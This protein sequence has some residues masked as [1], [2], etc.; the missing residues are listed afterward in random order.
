[1]MRTNSIFRTPSAYEFPLLIKHLWITPLANAPDEQIVYRSERRQTYAQTR[2]RVGRLASMLSA[3]G[4]TQGKTVALL[5][6]DSH[7]YFECFFAIPMMGCVLQTVNIRLSPDQLLYTLNHAG[8]EIVLV[9]SDFLPLLGAVRDRL[10]T[11]KKFI[12]I[13]DGTSQADAPLAFVGEYEALLADADPDYAFADLD[14]NSRATT[15]YTTGTTGLPKGVY[16]SHRQIVL[17][18]LALMSWLGTAPA[19]GRLHREDVYMPMTPMF[20]VHAWGLPFV[21]TLMG[22]KQIY[23][24]RYSPDV[25]LRLIRDERVTFSHCVPTVL[26]MLLSHPASKDLDMSRLKVMVG[27]SALPAGLA[28]T[29]LERNIDVFCGYGMSE[30][31]PVQVLNHLSSDELGACRDEQAKLRTRTGRAIVL[32]EVS[33]VD[34]D[35]RPVPRD[36]RNRGEI[37]FRSPWLTQ[38]YVDDP[39]RSE[40]LWRGGVLHS[41]DIG[42]FTA[43]GCLQISDRLKDVIKS[44]G[45]WISSLDLENIISEIPGVAEVAVIAVAD[46][47]WGERPLALIVPQ[48][49]AN[50]GL[51]AVRAHL[52]ACA[53]RG[54][55]SKYG[56]PDR[57]IIV[58]KL[59]RTSVGKLDKKTL[60]ARYAG[61]S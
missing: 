42:C 44:G 32:C 57:V 58:E 25:L 29:A 61:T 48:P 37:V 39:E 6:W 8:A 33:T 1:M 52:S 45:E 60:R 51:A 21:A 9:H 15:F 23:P 10:E 47:Q 4:T 34:E 28:R 27:G 14:E 18:A 38:G 24:G 43:D 2:E 30:T 56:I 5:D 20:H 17:H 40:E 13:N 19:Q 46:P 16:F 11:V 31:G 59:A 41:G 54:A 50:L 26:Q 7:R 53:A 49:R 36:G 55:I 12:L 3:L 35:S 22:I